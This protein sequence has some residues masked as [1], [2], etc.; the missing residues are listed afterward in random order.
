[1]KISV[2]TATGLALFALEASAKVP[3]SG[4]SSAFGDFD[5]RNININ[6][7]IN[8]APGNISHEDE[9]FKT[10]RNSHSSGLVTVTELRGGSS[11]SKDI[12]DETTNS[13]VSVADNDNDVDVSGGEVGQSKK[14]G[15]FRR[16]M[17][18]MEVTDSKEDNENE[19]EV[20]PNLEEEGNEA[21]ED[22]APSTKRFTFFKSKLVPDAS[23]GTIVESTGEN[24][25]SITADEN[26]NS[27][28]MQSAIEDEDSIS[29]EGDAPHKNEIETEVKSEKK[30][31]FFNRRKK[32]AAEVVEDQTSVLDEVEEASTPIE[33][34]DDDNFDNE[35]AVKNE[36][37]PDKIDE[38]KDNDDD[39]DDME[40]VICNVQEFIGE[41]RGKAPKK[42]FG[43]F[44]RSNSEE[45]KKSQDF[46]QAEEPDALVKNSQDTEV[47]KSES[48]VNENTV[49]PDN[50]SGVGG[51]DLPTLQEPDDSEKEVTADI[52]DKEK[53]ST[54]EKG[55]I[56][57]VDEKESNNSSFAQ[58]LDTADN[59]SDGESQSKGTTTKASKE[60]KKVGSGIFSFGRK[61]KSSASS[62]V[63][64]PDV[65]KKDASNGNIDSVIEADS[66]L[67]EKQGSIPETEVDSQ[68]IDNEILDSKENVEDSVLTNED[69]GDGM[70]DELKKKSFDTVSDDSSIKDVDD[71][72]QGADDEIMDG[73]QD[74][75]ESKDA[76][77]DK[78][79][80]KQNT[81]GQFRFRRSIRNAVPWMKDNNE[82][83]NNAKPSDNSNTDSDENQKKK[84][85]P[86]QQ[87]QQ[88]MQPMPFGGPLP[89]NGSP[90][91]PMGP[92][93]PIILTLPS[94]ISPRQ[95]YPQ[96]MPMRP[97][98]QTDAT[99]AGLVT[100]LLPLLSRLAILTFLSS[101]SLFG[102]GES[103]IYVPNPSQ[104]FMFERLNDRYERD[105]LAMQKALTHPPHKVYKRRWSMV[106]NG[107]KGALKKQFAQMEK[108][109]DA[110]GQEE[111]STIPSPLYSRTVIVL[112]FQTM[113]GDMQDI[114]KELSD[115][116]TFI[117]SQ[118]HNK[119]TRLEM[120]KDLEVIIC[121][122]SP[123]GAVQD[124]GLAADQ[125][126]RLKEAAKQKD[127]TLTV[128]VDKIAA[129][130]GYLMAC[131][132]TPG[133]LMAAPFAVIGSIGVLRETMNIHDLLKKGFVRPLL[134]TAGHAKAPLTSTSE[135]TEEKLA[136]VQ[137]DLE[138]VH[139]AFRASV[140]DARGDAITG[141]FDDVTNGNIFLGKDAADK[142]LVDHL[143]T[144]D[145]YIAERVQAG[146][147]V[148]R[149]HKYD[150]NRMGHL[151]L[152]PLDLLLLK[153]TD[154]TLGK[155][156]GNMMQTAIRIGPQLMK[157]GGMMGAI[158]LA[159]ENYQASSKRRRLQDD[160]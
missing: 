62:S 148:L 64:T 125:L 52:P 57:N 37:E 6:T 2:G 7:N 142:G 66:T 160:I 140:K 63:I 10:L 89:A 149:L 4:S 157:V 117:L 13:P 84:Q 92:S 79:K 12:G 111:R 147:R 28:T 27:D 21:S 68:A 30:V 144:S 54:S 110:V 73:Q 156:F 136:I 129:S 103:Q 113:K 33:T 16:N 59:S 29:S 18:K 81:A 98:S 159:D 118:Y 42:R 43:F 23:T 99:I 135:V 60:M 112:D 137:K 34:D 108:A 20:E 45:D 49:T 58:Y 76:V 61:R 11:T 107:R 119:C 106:L 82:S 26:T 70:D 77:N 38:A 85:Q 132:A 121:M 114:V 44:K 5:G 141:E 71:Q 69:N 153:T 128:C 139:D 155:M 151:R 154:G 115:A 47:T 9:I 94:A 17:K 143:K 19:K 88:P 3:G 95:R 102:H 31:G 87:Q 32:I 15:L 116:V 152:S 131:H 72:S 36:D 78:K 46:I 127:L 124:F 130:G 122:E 24:D 25:S 14:R 65:S 67:Q 97:Q 100:S 145:E 75:K 93:P 56:D 126:I 105:S 90:F 146:D 55:V 22:K 123:G 120:G 158:K 41:G 1:M 53:E 104:H 101:F 74:T 133:Q 80:K 35:I 39:D 40:E 86:L 134:L 96:G 48:V 138:K 8:A 109:I 91:D 51:E 150:R 83:S 50:I